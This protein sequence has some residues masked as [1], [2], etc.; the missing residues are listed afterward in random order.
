MRALVGLADILANCHTTRIGV[1]D[2]GHSGITVIVD[3]ADRRFGV[4]II[5]E[6]HRLA[7]KELAVG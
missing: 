6:A 5:V 2:H 1:L 3:R 7:A 4:L